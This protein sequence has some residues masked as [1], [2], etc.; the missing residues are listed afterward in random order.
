MVPIARWLTIAALF[1]TGLSAADMTLVY[2]GKDIILHEDNSWDYADKNTPDP[3]EDQIITLGDN[4]T[5]ILAKNY[6][7][8]FVEKEELLKSNDDLSVTVIEAKGSAHHAVLAEASALATNKA[9]ANATAKLKASVKNK[10]INGAKLLTCVTRVEKEVESSE[11]FVKGSGW[12][13]TVR[14]VLDKG[15]IR[16]ALDCEAETAGAAPPPQVTAPAA[17][18]APPPVGA[19][20]K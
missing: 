5:I 6:S 1:V 16:A 18:T 17:G 11:S 13:V 14:V 19:P 4:R 2:N 9:F 8:K 10:K 15:S 3:R 7:W 20:E 12:D